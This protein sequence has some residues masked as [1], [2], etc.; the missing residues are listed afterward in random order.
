MKKSLKLVAT[1]AALTT[2]TLNLNTVLAQSWTQRSVSE[3]QSTLSESESGVYII[4][5]GDTLS[6]IAEATG[7]TVNELAAVNEIVDADFIAAGSVLY[8]DHANNTVTYVESGS[9]NVATYEIVED[10]TSIETST[11]IVAETPEWI[12]TVAVE[13]PETVVA[14]EVTIAEVT[15]ALSEIPVTEAVTEESVSAET[16]EVVETVAPVVEETTATPVVVEEVTEAPIVEEVT[17]A[18]VV[19]ETQA[20]PA[21]NSGLNE[22][23]GIISDAKEWIAQKESGGNYEIWNPSGTYYGR[24]QLTSSY[25]NGDFSRE[26]QERVADKYVLERYGSWEAAKEF[27][28]QNNWY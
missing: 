8:F 10:E 27:W 21:T 3:V 1:A 5:W 22:Y 13:T 7:Y 23:G 28:L 25:L 20:E 6:T 16:A 26:N 9:T 14:E 12:E 2:L 19:E 24:Y 18:P 15:E 11:Y 17:A 4:Q